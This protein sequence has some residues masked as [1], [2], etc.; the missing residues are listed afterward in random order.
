MRFT[1]IFILFIFINCSLWA[2]K[3]IFIINIKSEININATRTVKSSLAQA[4]ELKVDY[5]I[6][7]MNTYG[8][9]L[10]EADKIKTLLLN[11]PKPVWVFINDNAASAGALISL[12]CDKIYMKPSA[13]I[14]AA[15]VV[16]GDDGMALPDKY[17]SYMRAKMRA[18]ANANHRNAEL[19]EAMVDPNVVLNDSIKK[20]G[21]VLTLSTKEAI[22]FG[23]CDKQINHLGEIWIINKINNPIIYKYKPSVSDSMTSFLM[24]DF[25]TALLIILI[26][27][28][29]FT[30]LSSFTGLPTAGIVIFGLMFFIPRY[31]A[32]LIQ[33]W[34]I[35]MMVVGIILLLLEIFVIPGFGIVGILGIVSVLGSLGLMML[36]NDNLDMSLVST[37]DIT[38]TISIL[39]VC[40]IL[41]LIGL[42][43][44]SSNILDNKYFRKIAL[45]E[46]LT[47]T[48]QITHTKTHKF[49]HTELIGKFAKTHTD[50]RPS[51]KIEFENEIYDAFTKGDYISKGSIVEIVA[52]FNS[53]LVVKVKS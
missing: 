6:V 50:L 26:L 25:V 33:N 48:N 42:F 53:S 16:N 44:F 20:T 9:L 28:A 18:V 47:T 7:D 10:D 46:S 36:N 17:Q 41:I 8:G 12:A 52:V 15:T 23:F 43:I 31:T 51:G 1:Q 5:I 11:Y 3:K 2:Q 35:I 49:S 4:T 22:K 37:H 34:E 19:A 38:V 30:E 21:Q 13:S 24:N 27:L 40:V 45:T 32:G 39:L 14:G 29:L